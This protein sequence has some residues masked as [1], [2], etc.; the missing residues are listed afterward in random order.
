MIEHLFCFVN[1]RGLVRRS[2]WTP[3]SD[4][5]DPKIDATIP[6][7]PASQMQARPIARLGVRDRSWR[8]T[9]L[10]VGSPT[11]PCCSG[12]R[13][14]GPRGP[15]ASVRRGLA[16]CSGVRIERPAARASSP[17]PGVEPRR[18]GRAEIGTDSGLVFEARA[19]DSCT[20]K[21]RGAP[22]RPQTVSTSHPS[23]TP[24]DIRQK[25]GVGAAVAA[26]FFRNTSGCGGTE[27]SASVS[28]VQSRF[29]RGIRAWTGTQPGRVEV[30][31]HPILPLHHT[32][33]YSGRIGRIPV[34]TRGNG[35][36]TARSIGEGRRVQ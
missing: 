19:P 10:T 35:A 12:I 11:R 15:V 18:S 14:Q 21:P 24:V 25:R 4:R 9:T 7:V 27:G 28:R 17:G 20:G 33:W 32:G 23:T 2:F 31:S 8:R 6:P 5:M 3:E 29:C 22:I 36:A 34:T 13:A 26:R 30:G 1:G 16:H